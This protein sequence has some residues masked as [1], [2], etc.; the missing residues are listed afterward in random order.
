MAEQIK[1]THDQKLERYKKKI[2]ALLE[3]AKSSNQEEAA[4][5]SAKAMQLCMQFNIDVAEAGE[6]TA[7]SYDTLDIKIGRDKWK[8]LLL[9]GLCKYN[10]CRRFYQA[11]YARAYIVGEK[12]NR[13]LVELMVYSLIKSLEEMAKEAYKNYGVGHA[14]HWKDE[15]YTGATA[16]IWDRLEKER[17]AV[18]HAAQIE[19]ASPAGTGL[20]TQTMALIVVK[21]DALEEACNRIVKN[22]RKEPKKRY[23]FDTGA[24][25]RGYED[26]K[27]V[28]MT[29]RKQIGAAS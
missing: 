17:G 25:H 11:R 22:V 23:K 26:G 4:S 10:F 19:A 16:A 14:R 24:F 29:N 28:A 1:E 21:N 2:K 27:N 12:D 20:A 15:Y 13:E 7:D 5:A 6:W 9:D 3:L 18:E 8:R